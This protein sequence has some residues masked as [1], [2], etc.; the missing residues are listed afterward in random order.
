[1]TL[2]RAPHFNS[3]SDEAETNSSFSD[4]EEVMTFHLDIELHTI[5]LRTIE[6]ARHKGRSGSISISL[7][8]VGYTSP[9]FLERKMKTL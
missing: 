6:L 3:A 9:I 4:R 2:S 7:S 8:L 1:M 5:E